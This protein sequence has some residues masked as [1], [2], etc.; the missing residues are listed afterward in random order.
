M[1]WSFYFKNV[2]KLMFLPIIV[3]ILCVLIL[4][5]NIHTTGYLIQRDIELS[6]GK[7]LSII[8]TDNVKITDVENV[9]KSENIKDVNVRIASSVA[10]PKRTILIQMPEGVD[11]KKI[12]EKLNFITIEDYSIKQVGAALGKIFWHQTKLAI[13]FA[14]VLMAVVVLLLFRTIVPSTAVV[15]AAVADITITITILSLIGVKLS[16]PI[17]AALLMLIGYSIDTDIL[18]TSKLLKG[19]GTREEKLKAAIKTG[20]TMSCTTLAA[21]SVLY[22]VTSNIVLKQIAMVLLFGLL[23]D[24]PTTWLT[25]VGILLRFLGEKND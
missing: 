2:K 21:I 7:L 12:I 20:L 4:G 9:L 1:I 13:F 5:Y 18:L 22:L 23:T 6:G 10:S 8:T 24:I 19:S 11:E 16:L 14:F 25:N 3:F 15:F 17:L